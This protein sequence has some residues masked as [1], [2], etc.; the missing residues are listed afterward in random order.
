[1]L[2]VRT[3]E[4]NDRPLLDEAAARDFYHAQ[5][6]LTGEHWASGNTLIYS[7]E[8]GYTAA[9]KVQNTVRLDIQF[10][11]QDRKRNLKSLVEGFW[12]LIDM[13]KKRGVE[14]IIFNSISQPVIN[15]FTKRF[16]F[17]PIGKDTYSLRI[18]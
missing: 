9:L 17:R 15:L 10:L 5:V 3:V 8:H 4:P 14:E 11:T 6:G 18:I 1:M 7:D 16:H 13:L 12:P 2:T